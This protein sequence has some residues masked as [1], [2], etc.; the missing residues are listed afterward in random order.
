MGDGILKGAGDVAVLMRDGV[1]W[2]LR[3]SLKISGGIC[4]LWMMLA[5]DGKWEV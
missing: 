3:A 1:A 5:H 2:V 4:G